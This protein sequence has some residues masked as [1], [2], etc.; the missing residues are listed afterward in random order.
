MIKALYWAMIFIDERY[1]GFSF[2]RNWEIMTDD[3]NYSIS[4]GFSDLKI[5]EEVAKKEVERYIKYQ[6]ISN[7]IFISNY[8]KEDE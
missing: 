1:H 5:D 7:N 2:N 3:Y 6:E 8:F 4:E